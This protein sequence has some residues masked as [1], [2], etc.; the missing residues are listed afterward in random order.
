MKKR[1]FHFTRAQRMDFFS[2]LILF[3]ITVL[4]IALLALFLGFAYGFNRKRELPRYRGKASLNLRAEKYPPNSPSLDRHALPPGL[5]DAPAAA[6]VGSTGWEMA[7][8]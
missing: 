4:C 1:G 6:D 2:V 3:L 8:F 5:A 7:S